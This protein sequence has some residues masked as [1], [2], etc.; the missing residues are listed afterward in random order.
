MKWFR[1]M[2]DM[3]DDEFVVELEQIFGLEGYARWCKLL[4]AIAKQMN[5][6][7]K[8]SVSYPWSKWQ[9]ILRGKQKKLETFL[10]HLEN[11]RKIFLKQNG[12]I[13]EIGCRKLLDLRDEYT[14]KSGQTPDRC[15]ENVAPEVE[16]DVDNTFPNGKEQAAKLEKAKKEIFNIARVLKASFVF[17]KANDFAGQMLKK[18]MHPGAI[19]YA[20]TQCLQYKPKEPWSYCLRIC[21]K[22]SGN[23]Y[24]AE[25]HLRSREQFGEGRQD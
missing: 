13:L 12:N 4:E 6:T 5:K 24:E 7:D 14:K 2:S 9:T 1:H 8:C 18:R 22:E 3:S 15:Q 19:L 25:H 23:L 21:Q 10:E 11:Q 16:V 20:L 17:E